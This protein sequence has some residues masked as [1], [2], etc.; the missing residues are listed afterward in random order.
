ML[1]AHNLVFGFALLLVFA[2]DL[3]GQSQQP[4]PIPAETAN[5]NQ[6]KTKE[7]QTKSGNDQRGTEQSPFVVKVIGG[8]PKTENGTN[9][10][11]SKDDR[12]STDWWMFFATVGIGSIGFLQFIAFVVQAIYMR[13]SAGEMRKTTEAAQKVSQDQIAHSHKVER[14]YISGGGAQEIE[15]VNRGTQTVRTA[16]G[17]TMTI[18]LG[19]EN[20]PTGNF[21]V[22][23]NNY[24]KTAGELWEVGV[25]F[26]DAQNIPEVPIYDRQYRYDWIQ[27]GDRGRPILSIAIPKD[28]PASAVYGRFFYR[29][30]FGNSHSC[31]FINRIARPDESVPILAPAAY[32][33]ERD[34]P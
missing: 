9:T 31:G 15:V 10:P 24:G 27:P 19:R 17:S 3:W 11:K 1:R 2:G 26:C 5:E 30:I 13:Q 32:T 16:D 23:V 18:D 34:E 4:P 7:D 6:T 8:E 21:V 14:A 25:G 33:E 12:N 22:C 20:I 28:R 29:D